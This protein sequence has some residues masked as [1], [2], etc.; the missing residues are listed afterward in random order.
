MG[1]EHSDH[2]LE[3]EIQVLAAVGQEKEREPASGIVFHGPG[4]W[5]AVRW[6][7]NF[8][9]SSPSVRQSCWPKMFGLESLFVQ[10]TAAVLSNHIVICTVEIGLCQA[11]PHIEMASITLKN[12]RT[13]MLKESSSVGGFVL[14]HGVKILESR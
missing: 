11:G 10:L 6:M 14:S 9:K 1:T 12:S 4:M 5:R 7:L 2:E 8:A 13:L 3:N